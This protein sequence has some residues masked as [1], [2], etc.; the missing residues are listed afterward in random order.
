[1]SAFLGWIHFWLY[2]KIR[3]VVERENLLYEQASDMC[4]PCADEIRAGAWESYGEPLPDVDLA[5]VI[6]QTN[7][8]GWLQRQ[9]S[10]AETR[11]AAFV[12]GLID[13]CPG[14]GEDII[15]QV[16]T[17]HGEK[18]G[19]DAKTN[20]EYNLAGADGIYKAL[21]DYFLNG[22]PCDQ[23]D[24]V[25]ESGPDKLVWEGTVCLKARHW[26]AA[27][28]DIDTM[29]GFYAEWLA[30]FVRGANGAFKFTQTKSSKDGQPIIRNEI[31]KQ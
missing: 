21:N 4:G 12:K 7:I 30:G 6:D 13:M 28:V 9:I 8:H 24:M 10:V 25:V 16:F 5:E 26:Q 20:E 27:G 23:T 31:V 17:Q 18:C 15:S 1:M 11:E 19:A 14:T 29:R 3:L 22:M 2:K